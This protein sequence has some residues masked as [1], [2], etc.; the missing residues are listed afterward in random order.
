MLNSMAAL[1]DHVKKLEHRRACVISP[2]PSTHSLLRRLEDSDARFPAF[3]DS[4]FSS[5]MIEYK[6]GFNK[7]CTNMTIWPYSRSQ[8]FVQGVIK[9]LVVVLDM[10]C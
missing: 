4:Q 9:D 10:L 6:A 7:M 1:E 2:E 5:Q 3:D 8:G